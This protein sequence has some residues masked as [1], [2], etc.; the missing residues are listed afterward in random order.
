[1][2][3]IPGVRAMA[4]RRRRKQPTGAPAFD[5]IFMRLLSETP[6][7][8]KRATRESA[9]ALL[10]DLR[11]NTRKEMKDAAPSTKEEWGE[12]V[13][14]LRTSL[15][16]GQGDL[17]KIYSW[18]C[19]TAGNHS[20]NYIAQIELGRMMPP[21]N[22]L[23]LIRCLAHVGAHRVHRS[24]PLLMA[25]REIHNLNALTRA[26]LDKATT[27]V[28]VVG[29]ATPTEVSTPG[30]RRDLMVAQ[31]LRHGTTFTYLLPSA[32][33]SDRLTTGQ[34]NP[35]PLTRPAV[36]RYRQELPEALFESVR[37]IIVDDLPRNA[38]D[39][40]YYV[41]ERGDGIQGSALAI[42][43]RVSM[44]EHP[45]RYRRIPPQQRRP[46]LEWLAS[47]PSRSASAEPSR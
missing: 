18:D 35:E 21:P 26:V 3:T 43:E 20:R 36:N 27:Q 6:W 24:D 4:Q 42:Q 8:D 38:R 32:E 34:D 17:A 10:A 23:A 44:K 33:L 13:R 25:A 46:L 39:D 5:R 47:V 11:L 7:R 37:A 28:Y 2:A 31:M 40:L 45:G 15:G 16:M 30:A 9:K 29:T 19:V 1:M 22:L 41:I 14:N 12:Y